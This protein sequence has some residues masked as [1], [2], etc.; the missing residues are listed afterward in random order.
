MTTGLLDMRTIML[1][2]VVSTAICAMVMALL[3]AQGRH[4]LRG[5]GFWMAQFVLQF[6]SS[7]LFAARDHIPDALSILGGN[8]LAMAAAF[9]LYIGLQRYAG[10]FARQW[11]NGLYFAAA[12]VAHAYF[13]F[14]RPDLGARTVNLSLA[15]FVYCSQ[16]ADLLLRRVERAMRRETRSAGLILMVFAL[17][18][19]V[20]VVFT[21]RASPSESMLAFGLRDT[22][23]VLAYQMLNIALTFAL[24][25]MVNRRL[26][27]DLER[28]I[29]ER[30]A[31][32]A[33]RRI[34]DEKFAVVFRNLPDAILL[35]AMEDGRILEANEAFSRM[36]GYAKEDAAGKTTLDLAFWKSGADREHMV[37]ELEQKGSARHFEAVFRRRSGGCFPG[38][39]F[40]E[41]IRIDDVPCVLMVVRDIT[42]QKRV[43]QQIE[44]SASEAK[45]LLQEAEESR[46]TLLSVVEDQQIAEAAIQQ[47]LNELRRWQT[48]TLGRED[49]ILELKREV[50]EL[51]AKLGEKSRY[52]SAG[53]G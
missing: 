29:R 32:E 12:I 48:V 47:Q 26:W 19:L 14:V 21:L 7:A 42:E 13:T 45:R 50:N 52:E 24:F 33:A 11:F 15:L 38:Q 6:V 8:A 23:V 46:R 44:A 53:E 41:V 31:A 17:I 27:A 16:C 35:T 36:S 39:C 9:L 3:W 51:A 34:S 37:K 20:R 43:E 30:L 18:S 2:A 40:A 49:R 1:S 22:S 25:L 5:L 10:H 4:R 28:D